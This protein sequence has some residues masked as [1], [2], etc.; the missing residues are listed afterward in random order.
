[1]RFLARSVHVGGVA[2]VLFAV[3]QVVGVTAEVEGTLA[4]PGVVLFP[5]ALCFYEA[6]EFFQFFEQFESFGYGRAVRV[7]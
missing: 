5:Q 2:S 1:M 6:A 7:V 4:D 3:R